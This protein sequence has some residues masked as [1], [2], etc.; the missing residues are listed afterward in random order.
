M[1]ATTSDTVSSRSIT[2]CKAPSLQH[3]PCAGSSAHHAWGTVGLSL[4][5]AGA[6]SGWEQSQGTPH[7][8]KG[9]T[10]Y[11]HQTAQH[12]AAPGLPSIASGIS[13]VPLASCSTGQSSAESQ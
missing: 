13:A 12:L 8:H 2:I 5:L 9:S 1:M 4:G 3:L 6:D 7:V 10:S 11:L